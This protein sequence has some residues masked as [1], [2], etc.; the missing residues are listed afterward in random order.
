MAPA[1]RQMNPASWCALTEAAI[2][3]GLR[4]LLRQRHRPLQGTSML[5]STYYSS[6][7]CFVKIYARC[8]RDELPSFVQ[9][10]NLRIELWQ[11]D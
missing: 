9:P 10:S 1:T 7:L 4:R 11:A 6:L 3:G 2:H 5:Y 8:L